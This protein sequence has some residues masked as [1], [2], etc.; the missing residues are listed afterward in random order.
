VVWPQWQ[1]AG[2]S[3]VRALASEVPLE[4]ARRGDAL[5]STILEA[6]L[7][8]HQGPTVTVPV[9]LGDDGLAEM[10]GIEAKVVVLEQ[11]QAALELIRGEDPAR[12]TTLGGECSV[13][14]A[15]FSV[16]AERYGDAL[17]IV[18]IDSHPDV[19][20][21]TPVTPATMQWRSRP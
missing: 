6:V 1:G 15:P 17:A 11:L 7:P 9:T 14:V 13:S 20:T 8:P 3:S 19:D 21:V 5:G 12:I 2:S 18:W 16:L 10:D 4:V